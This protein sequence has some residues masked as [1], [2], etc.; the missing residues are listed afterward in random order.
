MEEICTPLGGYGWVFRRLVML[1]VGWW[2]A[3]VLVLLL[4][5]DHHRCEAQMPV[6]GWVLYAAIVAAMLF[7][8]V[9]VELSMVQRLGLL[10]AD[11]FPAILFERQWLIPLISTV[12]WKLDSYLDMAFIFVAH[13]CGSSLWQA[14]LCV[15]VFGVVLGQLLLN[16]GFAATDCDHELPSSFG[17]FLLDFKLVN[18]AVLSIIPFNPDASHL[19]VARPVT[20]RTTGHFIGMEKVLS[21]LAQVCIQI[22]YLRSNSTASS[23]VMFSVL[24]GILHGTFSICV[25]V[26]E[27]VTDEKTAIAK[28]AK[29]DLDSASPARETLPSPA[30]PTPMS[31]MPS[32]AGPSPERFGRPTPGSDPDGLEMVDLL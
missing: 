25:V 23:F 17:F 13:D 27:W 10:K 30:R 24:V 12:L 5:L 22:V 1:Y 9:L 11:R 2:V 18:T 20:L 31:P 28:T 3:I 4:L 8:A 21:D 16:I 15:V 7:L 19:P 14:S 6:I 32:A 26:R 29:L